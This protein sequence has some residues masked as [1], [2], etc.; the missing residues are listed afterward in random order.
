MPARTSFLVLVLV[1]VC[2]AEPAGTTQSVFRQ[3][4]EVERAMDQTLKTEQDLSTMSVLWKPRGAYLDGYGAVFTVE[5]NLVPTAAISPFQRSYDAEQ[6]RQL[7]IRKRQK[8]EVLE[9]QARQMLVGAGGRLTTVPAKEKV[10]LVVTLFYYHWEDVTNLPAQMVMQA[11]R[12]VLLDREAGRLEKAEFRE[13]LSVE[14][15]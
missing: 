11:P 3:V 15:F 5:L 9:E 6:I 10:A 12:Q 1:A 4:E 2:A 8:L 14:Y 13:K 7:N